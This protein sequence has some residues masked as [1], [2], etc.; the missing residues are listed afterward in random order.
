[1]QPA[2]V[3][4]MAGS[5]VSGC[6]SDSVGPASTTD[7]SGRARTARTPPAGSVASASGAEVTAPGMVPGAQGAADPLRWARTEKVRSADGRNAT[8]TGPPEDAPTTSPPLSATPGGVA[9]DHPDAPVG[10]TNSSQKV[11]AGSDRW[12]MGSTAMA[13]VDVAAAAVNGGAVAAPVAPVPLP[14]LSPEVATAT[15]T[16][17]ATTASTTTVATVH[18]RLTGAG[19]GRSGWRGVH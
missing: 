15:M 17:A 3:W 11:L 19:P 6:Q 1:M 2:T 18:R 10:R 9:S 7:G 13:P 16:A 12:P 5:P 4:W 8:V 14:V